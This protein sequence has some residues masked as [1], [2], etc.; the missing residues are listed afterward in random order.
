VRVCVILDLPQGP[1]TEPSGSVVA[2]DG[3]ESDQPDHADHRHADRVQRDLDQPSAVTHDCLTIELAGRERLTANQPRSSDGP[4]TCTVRAGV[5]G[6]HVR[7]IAF[8]RSGSAAGG[9]DGQRLAEPQ[10]TSSGATAST[11]TVRRAGEIAHWAPRDV[12]VWANGRL[13]RIV[14]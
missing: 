3:N 5:T 13:P 9:V 6:F 14:R 10:P 2:E 1:V 4:L 8:P 11:Y 7:A 12:N